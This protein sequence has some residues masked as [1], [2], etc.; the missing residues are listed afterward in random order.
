MTEREIH[1]LRDSKDCRT[2]DGTGMAIQ[3]DCLVACPDC[4]GL[5]ERVAEWNAGDFS[6]GR[7]SSSEGT[8]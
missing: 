5:H 2:C 6:M 3:D 4:D 1:L 8:K 7:G